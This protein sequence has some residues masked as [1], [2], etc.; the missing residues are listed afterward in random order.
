MKQPFIVTWC[1][2]NGKCHSSSF[3]SSRRRNTVARYKLEQGFTVYVA[4]QM[5]LA[6]SDEKTPST[7]YDPRYEIPY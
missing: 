3:A 5:Q 6:I 2:E 4:D 7:T 1:D